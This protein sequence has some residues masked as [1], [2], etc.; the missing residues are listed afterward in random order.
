MTRQNTSMEV[1][2]K[3]RRMLTSK[4]NKLVQQFQ[5]KK[6]SSGETVKRASPENYGE[7]EIL[8]FKPQIDLL[9]NLQ[10]EMQSTL[11]PVASGLQGSQ[12]SINLTPALA[13]TKVPEQRM[14]K[15]KHWRMLIESLSDVAD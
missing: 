14:S 11:K 1:D 13:V 3:I 7:S 5:E 2:F 12:A 10:P 9:S 8:N 4:H 15:K 6:F